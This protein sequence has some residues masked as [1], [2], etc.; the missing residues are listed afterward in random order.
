MKMM[1]SNNTMIGAII[2]AC[3]L[4]GCS[5][6]SETGN[7]ETDSPVLN[8]SHKK[9]KGGEKLYR[10][11]PAAD[12]AFIP[13]NSPSTDLEGGISGTGHDKEAK[14]GQSF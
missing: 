12:E 14:Q 13:K 5:S 2:I 6:S 3:C 1:I 10:K 9:S 11:A 7:P 8:S 4:Q